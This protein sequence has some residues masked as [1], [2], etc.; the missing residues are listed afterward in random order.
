MTSLIMSKLCEK[1]RKRHTLPKVLVNSYPSSFEP[2]SIDLDSPN[3]HIALK[4]TIITK[5][6]K[7]LENITCRNEK[8]S[9]KSCRKF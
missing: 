2:T 9:W 3:R 4:E 1:I 6:K 5:H 8:K 7:M